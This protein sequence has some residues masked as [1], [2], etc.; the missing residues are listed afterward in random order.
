MKKITILLAVLFIS[1]SL[2]A[3]KGFK[4]PAAAYC[5]Y[6]GYK[7]SVQTDAR[8][9][10]VGVVTLPNGK[11][12]NAWDFYRGKIGQE[13]SYAALKGYEIQTETITKD[14]YT[15]E[16]PVAVRTER[17]VEQRIPLDQLMAMFG[18]N[19]EFAS[20]GEAK[21]IFETAKIDPNFKAS[22]SLPT[23]FDWRSYN[24]H[25]YIGSV[26]DQGSCG[27][28]YAFG[29]TACAEGTYNYATGK[30]DS[31]TADFSEGYIAWC[32]GSMSAYS[33]HFNGC[34]GADYD[35][36]E[37][38]ALCDIGTVNESY[39]P[40]SQSTS[41]TCP[42]AATNAPKTK[43]TGWYRV[44]CSD[45]NAIKTA[46]MT[47]GVVDAAV[48][49]STAFQNYTGG[50]FSDAS[51][52][53]TGSPCYNTTTNHAISLVG[54]GTDA[55]KGDYWILRNSWGSSW[56][57]SGYMRIA[58]TSARIA[59]S[60]CYMTYTSD[61][62][63]TPT[64]STNSVSS[65]G[66]NS[67]VCGGNITSNGGN[68]V[69]ASGVVYAKTAGVTTSNGTVVSTSPTVTTGSYS[70]TMNG[71]TAGTTYYVNSFATNSKG[72]SYGAEKSFTTT[73]TAPISYCTS[74]G[75]S[76]S[77]EWIASVKIGSFTNTSTAAGYT[78]FT[79]KVVNLTAGTAA[80]ITLTPGFTSTT[81]AEYWKIYVD[82]NGDGD[83]DDAGELVY[84]GGAT[85]KTAVTGTITIPSSQAAITTRMR[86]SMKYNGSQTPCE[87]FSYGEV[88]D[89]TVTIAAGGA[90]TIPAVP[91]GLA[92]SSISTTS[93]TISWSTSSGATSYD[94]QFRPSG[95][96]WTTY[97]TTTT[98]K[99]VTGLT[100]NTTYQ[101]QVRANNS[102]GS[103]SYS[104][105]V[106]ANTLSQTVSYCASKGSNVTY[107][108]IDLVQLNEINRTS[109]SDGG[110]K[111][112]T[113]LT[114]NVGIGT[115]QTIYFS[116]GFKSTSYTEYWA[117]W[118]DWNQNGTFEDSEKMVTGSS[119]S[120]STLS[121]TFTVP[122]TATLGKTRM[123]VTMKYN[124]APT[125]CETFSY[126][127]V[128]DYSVN[129]VSNGAKNLND[130]NTIAEQ[131]G[132][133]TANAVEIYPN[134]AKSSIHVNI[135][136]AEGAIMV[137]IYDMRGALVKEVLHQDNNDIDI[138]NLPAGTYILRADEEKEP[139][140]ARFVKE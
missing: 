111:D 52:S 54:W 1:V 119:S 81:Y 73:G 77:Y 95:G 64:V 121:G 106:S 129:V 70:V 103:S 137:R 9:G 22:R 35:Y 96:S 66:N 5:E 56:G 88:E 75:N 51:T 139:L 40:Y 112:M 50:V 46:I 31:N 72:T 80:S 67:A 115:S 65:I 11:T 13:Y 113:S 30:Y 69:T 7:Y 62:T 44:A 68:T 93:M 123:R 21:D 79:S 83:F 117:V 55:T 53:C 131:I 138:S 110:Y 34:G 63:T 16:R 107:E 108:W 90:P 89:Y 48:Y 92:A 124:A 10:S 98:S 39:F 8:N 26:R 4:N 17:G 15:T 76:S 32:L 122:S 87:S 118:I 45:E 37:L 47:Y 132:N 102:A 28:C 105:V 12:V 140:T 104:A 94:L 20:K 14:G 126:G 24:G 74:Q 19:I 134:P 127:E 60:V 38:Q 33:S 23:T 36:M 27:D 3:Q 61:N 135:R 18:D 136:S 2:Y 97:N 41:Q 71:L 25:S 101:F 91:T 49:V 130:N 84:D 109:T 43:F 59:C 29:A 114:A 86:V 125:S 78:D 57:E 42:S 128:E 100:A 99:A 58:V 116:A 85:S 133:E 82:L 6:L 120:S